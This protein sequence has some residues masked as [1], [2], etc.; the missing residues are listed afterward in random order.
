[1]SIPVAS[2][3]TSCLLIDDF[4]ANCTGRAGKKRQLCENAQRSA[5]RVRSLIVQHLLS[6]DFQ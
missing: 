3:G 2:G 4:P 1:M 5:P 6:G